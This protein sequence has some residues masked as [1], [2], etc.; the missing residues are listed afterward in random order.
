VRLK[1]L[2][3]NA[4]LPVK[5]EGETGRDGWTISYFGA[6]SSSA[7]LTSAITTPGGTP[8]TLTGTEVDVRVVVTPPPDLTVAASVP[9]TLKVYVPDQL[10]QAVVA[11]SVQ[12]IATCTPPAKST[13]GLKLSWGLVSKDDGSISN[14]SDVTIAYNDPIVLQISL[15]NTGEDPARFLISAPVPA[16]GT[17]TTILDATTDG[18]PVAAPGFKTPT[19][20]PGAT[21]STGMTVVVTHDD[22]HQAGDRDC[23]ALLQVVVVG[24]LRRHDDDPLGPP[25][26]LIIPIQLQILGGLQWSDDNVVWHDVTNK[27]VNV[28][29][30]TTMGFR[31]VLANSATGWPDT[32]PVKPVWTRDSLPKI[33]TPGNIVA[34]EF[35]NLRRGFMPDEI[36]TAV[37]GNSLSVSVHVVPEANE[38]PPVPPN[39]DGPVP[40]PPLPQAGT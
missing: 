5:L 10:G 3:L 27:P 2:I 24:Q 28:T 39:P 33:Q 8:I 34:Y 37:C 16:D 20:D 11:D 29:Q 9:D 32:A 40:T 15:T 18:Q 30:Y 4:P 14:P 12:A 7:D 23:H 31:A 6:V 1:P 36:V 35:D 19:I 26:T 25:E 22:D 38:A 17:T 21:V 13:T